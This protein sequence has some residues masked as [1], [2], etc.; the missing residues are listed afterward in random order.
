MKRTYSGLEFSLVLACTSSSILTGSKTS[1]AI[2]VQ[3]VTVEPY[4]AGFT[5]TDGNDLKN[6]D[7]E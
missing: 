7:L 4:D 3:T 5:D 2:G 6:L 1:V